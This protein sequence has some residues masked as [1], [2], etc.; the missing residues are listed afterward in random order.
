MSWAVVNTVSCVHG[1]LYRWK[2][3][4]AAV[5]WITVIPSHEG[6]VC[7]LGTGM[8]FVLLRI[9]H[10]SQFSRLTLQFRS[11]LYPSL[12]VSFRVYCLF[13]L[14]F[15]V[16][17]FNCTS[18]SR[19]QPNMVST[20]ENV[21]MLVSSN[22]FAGQYEV[23]FSLLCSDADNISFFLLFGG[24]LEE[25]KAVIQLILRIISLLPYLSFF[26]FPVL[27]TFLFPSVPSSSLLSFSILFLLLFFL[28]LSL[29]PDIHIGCAC[30]LGNSRRS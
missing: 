23:F 18:H 16:L 12:L 27:F 8:Y 25:A 19:V 1:I 6:T 3:E 2:R 14:L 21:S 22:P 11:C 20:A 26:S 9:F 7:G 29:S 30:S 13:V 10:N 5:S 24:K 15:G 17:N 4:W 28:P